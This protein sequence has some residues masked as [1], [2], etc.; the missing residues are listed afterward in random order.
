MQAYT[1]KTRKRPTRKSKAGPT[2]KDRINKGI[3]TA[4]I[5]KWPGDFRM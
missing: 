1:V 5:E 2:K 4:T 3:H